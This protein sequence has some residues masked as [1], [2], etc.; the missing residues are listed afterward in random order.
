M[1]TRL[2]YIEVCMVDAESPTMKMKTVKV[3]LI[4]SANPTVLLSSGV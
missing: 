3:M 4:F 1:A 2:H